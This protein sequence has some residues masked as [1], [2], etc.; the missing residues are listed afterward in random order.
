MSTPVVSID[1]MKVGRKGRGKHWTRAQVEA[2]AKAAQQVTR[3]KM[4][5][6]KM[7]GWLNEG[8]REIWKKTLKAMKGYEILDRVDADVLAIYCDA[9]AN[10]QRATGMVQDEGFVTENI[11]GTETV[12][13]HVRAAQSYARIVLQYSEKL[14]LSVSA[15]AR[16]AKKIAE[17]KEDPNEDLFD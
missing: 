2:R 12:S 17:K 9:M 11:Q 14:G 7:P 13:A 3:K 1:K 15:R 5:M 16:L 10:Y 4:I 6:P 8:A